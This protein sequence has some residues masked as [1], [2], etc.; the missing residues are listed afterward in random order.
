M[1]EVGKIALPGK[2][3]ASRRGSL[4]AVRRAGKQEGA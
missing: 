1:K 2:I 3:E 4:I